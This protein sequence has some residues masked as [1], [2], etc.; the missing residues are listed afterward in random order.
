MNNRLI[1]L[2]KVGSAIF[3]AEDEFED[4]ADKN[5]IKY[6]PINPACYDIDDETKVKD[7]IEA[8]GVY[9]IKS[10]FKTLFKIGREYYINSYSLEINK[11]DPRVKESWTHRINYMYLRIAEMVGV[12]AADYWLETE[13]TVPQD[14]KKI[15]IPF[16]DTE[17]DNCSI[18]CPCYCGGCSLSDAER[19]EL[20]KLKDFYS[21]GGNN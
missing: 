18:F 7:R 3:L 20:K 16:C 6:Y 9:K 12:P 19:Q 1:K 4:W 13:K 2:N 15:R 11:E 14:Y 21:L 5:N 8:E 10:S 17:E